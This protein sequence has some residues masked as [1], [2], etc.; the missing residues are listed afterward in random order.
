MNRN[1]MVTAGNT[2]PTMGTRIEGKKEAAIISDSPIE[3]TNSLK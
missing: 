2:Q 1:A 3:I